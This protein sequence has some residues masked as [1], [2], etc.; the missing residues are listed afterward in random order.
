M[1]FDA[2]MIKVAVQLKHDARREVR[3][4]VDRFAPS[5]PWLNTFMSRTGQVLGCPENA[6]KLLE[7]DEVVLTFPEGARGALKPYRERPRVGRFSRGFARLAILTR[8]PIIPVAVQGFEELHP[9]L[10]SLKGLGKK[11]GFPGLPITPTFP[12]LGLLGLVP[13]PVKCFIEFGSPLS[14]EDFGPHAADDEEIVSRL[15]VKVRL[16]IQDLYEH[17]RVQRPSLLAR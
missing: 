15:S 12:L 9:V 10:F 2:A 14:T 17:L 3:A 5:M 8:T 4:L 1:V 7:R 13:P 16:I 11:L 6:L